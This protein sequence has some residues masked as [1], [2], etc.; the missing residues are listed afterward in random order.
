M[1]DKWRPEHIGIETPPTPVR[2]NCE[3]P[4][5]FRLQPDGHGSDITHT[6]KHILVL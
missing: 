5:C 1:A 3:R 4:R 6:D 2:A